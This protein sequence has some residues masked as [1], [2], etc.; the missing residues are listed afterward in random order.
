MKVFNN[1]L[2]GLLAGTESLIE[3]CVAYSNFLIGIIASPGSIVN[4]CAASYSTFTGFQLT[5]HC[6]V[7]DCLAMNNGTDGMVVS[8]GCTINKCVTS[9]NG[10]QGISVSAGSIVTK[11]SAYRNTDGF[12]CSESTISRCNASE[13]SRHGVTVSSS[14]SFV[15]GNTCQGNGTGVSDGA[16]IRAIGS[17]TRIEKNNV[18][19]ND[20]GIEVTGSGGNLI[21]CNSA[22]GNATNYVIAAGNADAQ[23]ITFPSSGFVSTDPWANF[24][25]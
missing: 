6:A 11:C 23:K 5:S 22:S 24:S 18:I 1:S 7:S 19:G 14:N 20:Y 3:D 25:F 13:N 17:D 2:F 21:I 10:G 12:T 15:M 16:G 4:K 8:D 9:N